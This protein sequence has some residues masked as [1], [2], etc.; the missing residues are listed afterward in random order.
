MSKV[1]TVNA[2]IAE[3]AGKARRRVLSVF[4]ANRCDS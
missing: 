1:T 2:E 4:S 3:R